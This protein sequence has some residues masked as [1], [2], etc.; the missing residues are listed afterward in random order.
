LLQGGNV[1]FSVPLPA[2]TAMSSVAVG[3]SASLLL[4]S[5][6][7]VSPEQGSALPL[8]VNTG[9]GT[10]TVN[11]SSKLTTVDLEQGQRFLVATRTVSGGVTT[12]GR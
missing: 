11:A 10:T 2:G 3:A 4:G 12:A 1:T 8:L 9:T 5:Q 6:V 7:E